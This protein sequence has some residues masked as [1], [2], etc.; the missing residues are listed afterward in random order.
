MLKQNASIAI[1][2][3][4]ISSSACA[5][6]LKPDS[7]PSQAKSSLALSLYLWK[8]SKLAHHV[9]HPSI[10]SRLH[11]RPHLRQYKRRDRPHESIAI[12]L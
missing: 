7:Y 8:E 9:P 12:S 1:A 2:A 6:Q 10:H 5:A 4:A 3:L 11:P